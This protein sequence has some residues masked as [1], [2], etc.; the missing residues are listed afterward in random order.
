[1]KALFGVIAVVLL[2]TASPAPAVTLTSGLL[3]VNPNSPELL[4]CT[5]VNA[6]TKDLTE[7]TV[8]ILNY[9]GSDVSFGT[10]CGTLLAPG[11]VCSTQSGPGTT[12]GYC[13]VSFTGSRKSPRATLSRSLPGFSESLTSIPVQ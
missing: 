12:E 5:V 13:T 11:A 7:L 8:Q 2:M 4:L 9:T 1:M 3:R 10:D 6:G